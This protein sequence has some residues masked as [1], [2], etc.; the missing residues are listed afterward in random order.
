MNN[1][2]DDWKLFEKLTFSVW[3]WQFQKG[4]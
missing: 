3:I 1:H 4:A 2:K